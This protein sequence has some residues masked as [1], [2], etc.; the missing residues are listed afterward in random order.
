MAIKKLLDGRKVSTVVTWAKLNDLRAKGHVIDFCGK[1]HVIH[2]GS[3]YYVPY[4]STGDDIIQTYN[5]KKYKLMKYI[6]NPI[7]AGPEYATTCW[8]CYSPI[9]DE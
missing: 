5:N 2:I 9:E 8:G 1:V 7:E 3:R 4:C 6:T